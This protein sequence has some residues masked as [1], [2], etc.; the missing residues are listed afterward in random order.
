MGG[1]DTLGRGKR[2]FFRAHR[3]ILYLD[4]GVGYIVCIFLKTHWIVHLKLLHFILCNWISFLALPVTVY[5]ELCTLKKQK[6][7]SL[8]WRLDIPNQ[9]VGRTLLSLKG[10]GIILPWLFLASGVCKHPCCSLA[11]GK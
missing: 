4:C 1:G 9:D 3:N 2:E 6:C 5:L 7:M 8:F 10:L 11:C